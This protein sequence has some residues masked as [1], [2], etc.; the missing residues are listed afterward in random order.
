M[1]KRS[2]A[3]PG[4]HGEPTADVE[5]WLRESQRAARIGSYELDIAEGTWRCTEV[6]DEIFG[7]DEIYPKTVDSWTALLHPDDQDE[8][9]RYFMEH[10]LG[11]RQPFEKDYRIVRRSD[12]QERWVFG[13]GELTVNENGDPVSMVGTIQDITER[14]TAEDELRESVERLRKS[15]AE[16]GRLLASLVVAQEE[17]R[18]R[19]ARELHDDAIQVMT[20]AELRLQTL[21]IKDPSSAEMLNTLGETIRSAIGRLRTSLIGLRP[22][23]LENLG[24]APALHAHMEAVREQRGPDFTVEDLW[25][26]QPGI[27]TRVTVYRIVLESVNNVRKH[28]DARSVSITLAPFDGGFGAVVHDDGKGFDPSAAVEGAPGHMGLTIMRERAELAGGHLEILSS[29]G[30]GTTV[31]FWVPDVPDMPDQTLPE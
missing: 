22:P 28:A 19:M 25:E 23:I 14:K 16:R 6:L 10:V 1:T 20:A 8:M 26:R 7:I 31:R 24:V 17:E 5:F 18:G 21:A 11:Q 13:R 27:E 9:T 30:E 2:D 4:D 3:V 15:D 29:P 12:G